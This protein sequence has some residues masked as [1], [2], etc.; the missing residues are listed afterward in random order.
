[1][2]L[3]VAM[4]GATIGQT[5]LLSFEAA[6]NQ[7]CAALLA[8]GLTSE[9]IPYVW[10][11]L[12]AEQENLKSVGQGG[13]QPN[14]SQTILK[15]YPIKVAPLP[16]QHRIVAKI[17]SLSAKSKRARDNL[18]HISRLVERFK[19]TI[20]TVA[21]RGALTADC[22][23]RRRVTETS[24]QRLEGLLAERESLGGRS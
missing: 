14:I 3:L 7:A 19:A 4:Y 24:A 12:I 23:A 9:L 18:D 17:D 5:G 13:A 20:L 2:T 22:Q 10:R 1:G 6:T 11:Y 8:R 21:F 16:E 15:E